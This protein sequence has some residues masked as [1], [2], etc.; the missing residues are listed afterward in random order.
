M[1]EEVANGFY[2]SSLVN[3]D[4]LFIIGKKY[5]KAS[6]IHHVGDD[7]YCENTWDRTKL[8]IND[9]NT[10]IGGGHEPERI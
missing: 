4:F 3:N 5:E 6:H 10:E 2:R 1:F 7:I 8:P 9:K